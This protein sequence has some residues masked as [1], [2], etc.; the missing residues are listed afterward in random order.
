MKL[1]G[2]ARILKMQHIVVSSYQMRVNSKLRVH[3]KR[4][5]TKYEKIRSGGFAYDLPRLEGAVWKAE[6]VFAI[7]LV[8]YGVR[9]TPYS[10]G[11]RLKM[12]PATFFWEVV[13]ELL[14]S[15]GC[16]TESVIA[17]KCHDDES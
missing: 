1:R 12:G 8:V 14:E 17:G 13:A 2:I 16:A 9:R 7:G 6:Q 3:L 15:G 5:L 11:L 4:N 10:V